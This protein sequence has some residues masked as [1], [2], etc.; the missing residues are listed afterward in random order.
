MSSS[1]ACSI[2]EENGLLFWV[3]DLNVALA[4]CIVGFADQAVLPDYLFW[5][6]AG[7]W[8]A[9][10]NLMTNQSRV[11]WIVGIIVALVVLGQLL[12]LLKW[13]IGFVI[14]VVV[15]GLVVRAMGSDTDRGP[16]P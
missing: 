16:H 10:F 14:L 5:A 2:P 9:R 8:L 4:A 7:D 6:M 13:A 1:V 15:I 11:L 12:A 3:D